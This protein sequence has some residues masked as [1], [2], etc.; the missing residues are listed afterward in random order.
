MSRRQTE[1][2]NTATGRKFSPATERCGPKRGSSSRCA[3]STRAAP[4]RDPR[5]VFRVMNVNR[6]LESGTHFAQVPE[7]YNK[8]AF[9]IK[10]WLLLAFSVLGFKGLLNGCP[11]RCMAGS[12]V[13]LNAT[14]H[15][16]TCEKHP[17]P[18]LHR[19]K[20]TARKWPV[21]RT[22]SGDPLSALWSDQPVRM[23]AKRTSKPIQGSERPAHDCISPPPS[24]PHPLT[25]SPHHLPTPPQPPAPFSG[26]LGDV[27]H[28]LRLRA[29]VAQHHSAQLLALLRFG[30]PPN[31][32][33][34]TPQ[35]RLDTFGNQ[36]L[37][38]LRLTWKLAEGL[39]KRDQV[40][41]RGPFWSFHV[42]PGGG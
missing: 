33:L 10:S 34:P 29:Q 31:Q 4:P 12:E 16:G 30:F 1:E 25:P 6:M 32:A 8:W 28:R 21:A 36:R 2:T 7:T 40:F 26:P 38:S 13:S 20:S 19:G 42:S 3:P 39:C 17:I 14:Q 5:V 37:Q 9:L 24:R 23:I 27:G 15:E 22:L 41:Q 18:V 11:S 35:K